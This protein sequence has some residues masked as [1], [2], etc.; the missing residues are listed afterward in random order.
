MHT[1]Q[2]DWRS[3]I[4]QNQRNTAFVILIFIAIYLLLGLFI[5]LVYRGGFIQGQFV[6]VASK[7]LTLQLFPSATLLL[8]A[9][10]IISLFITYALHDRIML[11][12][13]EYYEITPETIR[14]EQ[15]R[16]LYNIIEELKISASM[17][18]M[19]KVYLIDADYM[20]AFASGYSEK[21]AM[22]AITRGLMQ[23]LDRSEIQAVM[24]H[25]L[26]HIRHADIK[27]TLTASVLSNIIL[28]VLDLFFYNMLF[29]RDSENNGGGNALVIIIIV[30]RY[31]LP[32]ITVLLLLLL[33]RTR[34][35]MA[36]AG[37][38]ELT[39]DNH[40]LARALLKIEHDHQQNVDAYSRQYGQTKHEDV[41]KA[42]YI[43]D[44]FGADVHPVKSL[45]SM[46]STHPSTDARLKALGFQ[47]E[48][49]V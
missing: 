48:D 18:Y 41:R 10:A 32:L 22:V 37:S 2:T 28:I 16:Q 9:V 19:P 24:A 14:N 4:K 49:Q 5:D 21:S 15:D 1:K 20:N 35:Y 30:A 27:L 47:S 23:K 17:R 44:P 34:E 29:S 45:S 42:A 8:L 3:V 33:S 31:V 40:P 7:L 26:S 11:L 6:P 12:G 36:D 13:T 25:E 39:R 38:V 46:F 43:F